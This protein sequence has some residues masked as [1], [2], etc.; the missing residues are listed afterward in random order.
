MGL[1]IYSFFAE[2]LHHDIYSRYVDNEELSDGDLQW[3]Y[4]DF[5]SDKSKVKEALKEMEMGIHIDGHLQF[6]LCPV[7]ISCRHKAICLLAAKLR[8]FP[9]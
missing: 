9:E 4:A 8:I 1:Q 2:R 6:I 3:I 5:G 7:W